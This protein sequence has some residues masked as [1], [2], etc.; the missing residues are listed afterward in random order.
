MH[1]PFD[2][3]THQ[4]VDVSV[5]Q[6]IDAYQCIHVLTHWYNNSSIHQLVNVL[7]RAQRNPSIHQCIDTLMC[8][9][10][11]VLVYLAINVSVRW[12]VNRN[13]LMPQC[14]NALAYWFVDASDM[15]MHQYI[16]MLMWFWQ[17]DALMYWCVRTLMD[18]CIDVWT[19]VGHGVGQ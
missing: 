8:S 11:D 15:L 5:H 18:Q 19:H 17:P 13:T 4:C 7:L 2:T 16:V 6:Y 12:C 14:I 10:V 9:C 1:W 3:L